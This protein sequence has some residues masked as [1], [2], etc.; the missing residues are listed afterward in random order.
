MQRVCS[1]QSAM[2]LHGDP[3]PTLK[4]GV[5]STRKILNYPLNPSFRFHGRN[6]QLPWS[7]GALHSHG[8]SSPLSSIACGCQL[9]ASRDLLAR[10]EWPSS[11]EC[12]PRKRHVFW[13]HFGTWNV[14]LGS[15][16]MIELAFLFVVWSLLDH[17][18]II[19]WSLC[20]H[21]V[22]LRGS[23]VKWGVKA[24]VK[25]HKLCLNQQKWHR[26][27]FET[28]AKKV[29]GTNATSLHGDPP[30]TLKIGVSSTRDN[31]ETLFSWT[32]PDIHK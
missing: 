14:D 4:F 11:S 29:F 12:P 1:L 20:D 6:P 10:Y 5:S 28:S 22:K 2:T 8:I 19:M 24:R 21:Y 13:T 9:P 30:P 3:P 7:A 27:N 31:T 26:G 15:D 25:V 17:C 23:K 18:V 32:P 16:R